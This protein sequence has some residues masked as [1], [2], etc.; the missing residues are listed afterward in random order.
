MKNVPSTVDE[1]EIKLLLTDPKKYGDGI[2]IKNIEKNGNIM[3][4]EFES[5]EST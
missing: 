3:I 4:V 1:D 2:K 5:D